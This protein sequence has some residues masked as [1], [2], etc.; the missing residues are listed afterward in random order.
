[1]HDIVEIEEIDGSRG[2][3]LPLIGAETGV[4]GIDKVEIVR[5]RACWTNA[6]DIVA[7]MVFLGR[8]IVAARVVE[9][10]TGQTVNIMPTIG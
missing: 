6:V 2:E 1:V 9:F 8:D 3:V 4:E 10:V 7:V 5:L